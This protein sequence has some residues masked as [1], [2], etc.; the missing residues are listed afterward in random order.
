MMFKKYY[1]L[2]FAVDY[3]DEQIMPVYTYLARTPFK[4]IAKIKK[5]IY[6][7]ILSSALRHDKK[8]NKR[9]YIFITKERF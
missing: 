5:Q 7:K 9:S 2:Y 8:Y 4:F 3:C 6:A 1:C